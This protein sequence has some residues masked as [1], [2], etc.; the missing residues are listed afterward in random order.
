[1]TNLIVWTGLN[2]SFC[3]LQDSI[4][5]EGDTSDLSYATMKLRTVRR[6][7]D[8]DQSVTQSLTE[9]AMRV[10]DLNDSNGNTEYNNETDCTTIV[11]RDKPTM[12]SLETDTI[13]RNNNKV[14]NKVTKRVSFSQVDTKDNEPT[15]PKRAAT[16]GKAVLRRRPGRR[17]DKKK[18][19]VQNSMKL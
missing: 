17:M 14:N 12:N 13:L 9:A 10:C 6:R 4:E 16:K 15:E 7:K 11:R 1:V 8:I 3:T 19:K 2:P 18:V 5:L